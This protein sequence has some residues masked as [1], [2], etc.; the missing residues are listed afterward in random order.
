M[1]S[2]VDLDRNKIITMFILHAKVSLYTAKVND[3]SFNS[4]QLV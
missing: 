3:R 2:I 4:A 1:W